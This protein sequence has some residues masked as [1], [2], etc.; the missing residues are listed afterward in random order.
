[1]ISVVAKVQRLGRQGRQGQ[2]G[3][4]VKPGLRTSSGTPLALRNGW[5]ASSYKLIK[6]SFVNDWA[7]KQLP[8]GG[9]RPFEPVEGVADVEIILAL[10]FLVEVVNDCQVLT[11]PREMMPQLNLK[12]V[13]M[14]S[15][16]RLACEYGQGRLRTF[17]LSGSRCHSHGSP[18]QYAA[19]IR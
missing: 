8:E 4:R 5:Q 10:A 18:P 11:A 19:Q 3:P 6:S 13:A 17:C 16:C 1:M 7:G 15:R 9:S 12:R 14:A 2:Q